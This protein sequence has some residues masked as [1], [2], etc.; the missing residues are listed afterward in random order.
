M[1]AP[2]FSRTGAPRSAWLRGALCVRERAVVRS[3]F[4]P[5]CLPPV[6]RVPGSSVAALPP[7]SSHSPGV[8]TRGGAA[9]AVVAPARP[10][11]ARGLPR[12][13]RWRDS[14]NAHVAHVVPL[15]GIASTGASAGLI[16]APGECSRI[17]PFMVTVR[18][19]G[20][21]RAQRPGT[22]ADEG[23]TACEHGRCG[24]GAPHGTGRWAE[25]SR[26]LAGPGQAHTPPAPLHMSFRP[27]RTPRDPGPAEGAAAG[28]PRS[29]AVT[30]TAPETSL[31]SR[32]PGRRARTA[33]AQAITARDGRGAPGA[34]GP[35]V[36]GRAPGER[37][38][39]GRS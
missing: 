4:S 29:P 5:W 6:Q 33:P 2:G 30:A 17:P 37:E 15:S 1:A 23:E 31:T 10:N 11:P 21:A 32:R 28:A 36:P 34:K 12:R 18:P 35:S 8:T 20:P 19:A 7:P 39:G 22:R 24:R 14:S 16:R 9:V 26:L 38:T 3:A 27:E 25:A 13:R